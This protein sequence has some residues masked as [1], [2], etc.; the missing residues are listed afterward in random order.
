[1]SKI[2]ARKLLLHN[3]IKND[4]RGRRE[5]ERERERDSKFERFFIKIYIHIE[6]RE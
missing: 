1:M 2:R 6:G 3:S 5:R 4:F